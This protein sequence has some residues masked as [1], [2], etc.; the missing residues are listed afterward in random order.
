[1]I[2]GQVC[3]GFHAC[4]FGRLDDRLV[5]A[6]VTRLPSSVTRHSALATRHSPLGSACVS[7]QVPWTT[8]RLSQYRMFPMEAIPMA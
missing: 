5:H 4:G 7:L 1:M 8:R 3:P 2:E 6:R